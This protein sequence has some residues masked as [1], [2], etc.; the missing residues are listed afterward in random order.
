MVINPE[1][2][3]TT[4]PFFE[5]LVCFSVAWTHISF[6]NVCLQYFIHV[7]TN[8]ISIKVKV[9]ASELRRV[10]ALAKITIINNFVWQNDYFNKIVLLLNCIF[11]YFSEDS[12]QEMMD[13]WLPFMCPYDVTFAKA[14]LYFSLFLPTTLLPEKHDKGFK[15]VAICSCYLSTYCSNGLTWNPCS[16]FLFIS[17]RLWFDELLG[18]WQS[19]TSS[20]RWE[21]VGVH[22]YGSNYY[23]TKVIIHVLYM[24]TWYRNF[25]DA[26]KALSDNLGN[27]KK[28]S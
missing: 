9:T 26:V 22:G 15:Y 18:I 28:W 10:Q 12:T 16:V 24:C 20:S 6:G 4:E 8:L 1:W 17:S 25:S 21:E 3:S 5:F 2:Y 7:C 11:R 13:E 14:M 27:L 23:I 19:C